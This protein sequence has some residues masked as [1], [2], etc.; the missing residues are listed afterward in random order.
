MCVGMREAE[1]TRRARPAQGE[2]VEVRKATDSIPST[3]NILET[4]ISRSNHID[5]KI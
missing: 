4:K 5:L 1:G 3:G 2:T